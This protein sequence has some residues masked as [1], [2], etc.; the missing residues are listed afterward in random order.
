MTTSTP[1]SYSLAS[2]FEIDEGIDTAEWIKLERSKGAIDRS[3]KALIPW[4]TDLKIELSDELWQHCKTVENWRSCH[5]LPLNVFNATLRDRAQKV[6]PNVMIAQRLKRFS[7][8]MNKLVREP[9]M[10]LSQMQDLGGC[11]AVLPDIAAVYRLYE[12]YRE[13]DQL[14]PTEVAVKC[15]DYIKQPKTD[16]YRGIHVIGRYHARSKEREHWN[17]QRIEV[18][19]RTRLQHA[20]ATAVETVTTFTGERL[21][22]GAGPDEWRRFFSLA[23]SAF[24]LRE[25]TE[26]VE[27]TPKD[28]SEL[29]SELRDASKKLRVHERL[30]GWSD[31]L[32]ALPRKNIK[33]GFTWLLLVLNIKEKKTMVTGFQNRKEA[34]KELAKIEKARDLDLDAVLVWVP[35]VS[36]LRAAYPNYYADTRKF[37]EA[38]TM[39]LAKK[40]TSS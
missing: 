35:S 19:L 10:K 39:A 4:W 14:P 13:G 32:R 11:R 24:S 21:K 23:G 36:T 29:I 15:H 2:S 1:I 33:Q 8:I 3:G 34:S 17:G 38:L 28:V 5:A 12:M 30:T 18:Q 20:F 37:L 27:K 7:S 31:A 6:D 40:V 22:F 26:L 25:G 16:G 9:S